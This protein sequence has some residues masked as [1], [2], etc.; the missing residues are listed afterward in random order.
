MMQNERGST[1]R[2]Q[3]PPLPQPLQQISSPYLAPAGHNA[4]T[5]GYPGPPH[6]LMRQPVVRP[7]GQPQLEPEW[8]AAPNIAQ[9]G[10]KSTVSGQ[11]SSST[12]AST[13]APS[14]SQPGN[15]RIVSGQSSWSGADS[16]ESSAGADYVM[17]ERPQPTLFRGGEEEADSEAARKLQKTWAEVSLQPRHAPPR[18]LEPDFR[19]EKPDASSKH[20]PGSATSMHA[21]LPLFGDV[22]YLNLHLAQLPIGP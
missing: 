6:R 9:P 18:F 17:P 5:N 10:K 11:S 7:P 16:T 2:P 19:Q 20:P 4:M 13:A 14:A 22:A 15:R 12:T 21:S 8:K 1:W 3:Q